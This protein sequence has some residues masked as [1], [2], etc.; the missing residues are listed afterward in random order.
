LSEG[1]KF[2]RPV[3]LI[4]N[5]RRGKRKEERKKGRVNTRLKLE[6]CPRK[7]VPIWLN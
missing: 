3:D 1:E 2:E 4:L 7:E 6:A 5:F